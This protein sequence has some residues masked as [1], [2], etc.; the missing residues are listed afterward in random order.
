M[1]TASK[2]T[3]SK[4]FT[5]ILAKPLDQPDD[6]AVVVAAHG[7]PEPVRRAIWQAVDEYVAQQRMER[8]VAL[9]EYYGVDLERGT[10]NPVLELLFRLA[11]DFVPGFRPKNDPRNARRVGRP[12]S[13][14]DE[15]NFELYKLIETKMYQ[16]KVTAF[17][18]CDIIS[19]DRKSQWHGFTAEALYERYKRFKAKREKEWKEHSHPLWARIAKIRRARA[20]GD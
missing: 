6:L 11:A 9:A 4:P 18:A 10:P 3:R 7:Q 14:F 15:E 1:S 17:R 5:G 12:R 19:K 2:K 13:W 20:G 8:L 16:R